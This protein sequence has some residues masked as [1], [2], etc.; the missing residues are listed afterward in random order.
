VGFASLVVSRDGVVLKDFVLSCRVAQKKLENAWFYWLARVARASGYR[1]ICA[2]YGKTSRNGVLLN[3]LLEAGFVETAKNDAGSVLELDC[4][5]TP[6][7][8]DIVSIVA[9]GL[10]L[11]RAVALSLKSQVPASDEIGAPRHAAS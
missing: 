7:A 8:S 9:H 4:D 11:P 2:P 5:A 3:A 1:K 10:D 6:P